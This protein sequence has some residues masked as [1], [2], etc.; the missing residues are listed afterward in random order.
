MRT[1][2]H[3][4]R[5]EDPFAQH[6][7]AKPPGV[8]SVIIFRAVGDEPVRSPQNAAYLTLATRTAFTSTFTRADHG[9]TATYFARWINTKGEAGPWSLP[10][11]A[12]VA[13]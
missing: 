13:A 11:T 3:Q 5:A 6:R 8:A 4:L 1:G 10:M 12:P 9:K 7:R 2:F